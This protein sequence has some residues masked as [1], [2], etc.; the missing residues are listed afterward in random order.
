MHLLLRHAPVTAGTPSQHPLQLAHARGGPVRPSSFTSPLLL[1]GE[2]CCQLLPLVR[3][4][5]QE[6]CH[7]SAALATR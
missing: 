2:A 4:T 1:L 5:S 7:C 6:A 3:Q